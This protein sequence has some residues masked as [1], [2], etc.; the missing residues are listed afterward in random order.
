MSL[1]C[2][3]PIVVV[4]VTI[5]PEF[6]QAIPPDLPNAS[7]TIPYSELKALWDAARPKAGEGRAPQS[8]VAS[9]LRSA[10]FA[11]TLDGRTTSIA[12][13]FSA[14][15][16]SENWLFVPLV[17]GEVRLEGYDPP[18]AQLVYREDC[19]GILLAP[20][21][22]EE[23]QLR[24]SASAA[25]EGFKIEPS[26]ATS[27][28]LTISGVP[29]DRIPLVS[30]AHASAMQT[31]GLRSYVL[32]ADSGGVSIRL[33]KIRDGAED[34]DLAPSR[35]EM[36]GEALATFSGSKITYESRIYLHADD[37]EGDE[38]VLVLPRSARVLTA[39]GDDGATWEALRASDG[40]K[41]IRIR[42][43]T[44][45]ILDREVVLIWEVPQAPL[46]KRWKLIAPQIDGE[47]DGVESPFLFVVA[48]VE[49]LQILAGDGTRLP[50]SRQLPA[51]LRD[52]V[53]GDYV[54]V[55]TRGGALELAPRWLPRVETPDAT[56]ALAKIKQKLVPGGAVLTKASYE[57]EHDAAVKWLVVLPEGGEILSCRVGGKVSRPVLREG[58]GLEFSLPSLK[59][60]DPKST[61]GTTWVEF[62][63]ASQYAPLDPVE[64][65][66]QIELPLT[67]LFIQQIDWHLEI[68]GRYQPTAAEG[69]VEIVVGKKDAA[70]LH[71]RKQLCRGVRPGIEL[72]YRRAE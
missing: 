60:E 45:E 53:T 61:G 29:E 23:L 14:V 17:G 54:S 3:L 43:A 67:E 6:S 52:R 28:R 2:F 35:W 20:G 64:G 65:V 21:A 69:N 27:G 16:L 57:I 25:D 34:V 4:A 63:Y 47:V 68:P 9:I 32:A 33:E 18:A 56:V 49:G 48:E 13:D 71:F 72:Y 50:V 38:A 19:Y 31:P 62:S 55:S 51:W 39:N 10:N 36:V 66:L 44:Q 15:N 37:G 5:L 41:L 24:L 22:E 59:A 30:G 8:P 40:G 42:W 12:A 26:P 70:G 46:A 1:K 11:I 7:V 58:G